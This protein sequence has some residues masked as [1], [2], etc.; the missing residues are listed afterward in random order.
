MRLRFLRR[1][2]RHPLVHFAAIGAA[3]FA[4]HGA[5]RTVAEVPPGAAMRQTIII[6][7]DR[8][9]L[10]RTEFEHRWGAAP[11]SD[12]LRALI[13]RT[14]EEEM[15]FRQ[16]RTLALDFQDGSVR[17]RL[18]EKARAV[19]RR[20]AAD[21]GELYREA[22]ALGLEDDIVIRRLLAEK[23]R[24]FLQQEGD[25]SAIGDAELRA[26]LE[27]NRARFV[28][29]ET[30]TFTHVF[31]SRGAHHER[32]DADAAATLVA[33]GAEPPSP[34]VAKRSDPFPLGVELRAY[35]YPQLLGRFGKGFADAMMSLEPGRW[36][37][38][39]A[40]PYGLH[41]AWVHEHA[42]E[43]LPP[44][45]EVREAIALALMQQRAAA[46][47]EKGLTRLRSLYEIRI[48]EAGLDVASEGTVP[49][50]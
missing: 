9:R 4:L 25:G 3:L 50:S 28:Q 14:V 27:Q 38:P 18:I 21:A 13:E 1:S 41:L 24:L 43:R 22:I 40:S 42:P 23:M 26:Y 6:S 19:S 47:L 35:S 12:Q 36:S 11:S 29:P 8:I 34:E 17:R 45:D 15:L 31:L 39:I 33:L 5:W 46:N 7:A 37:G 10:L 49:S 30:V 44:L 2:L 32:L 16:A 20:P 48:E